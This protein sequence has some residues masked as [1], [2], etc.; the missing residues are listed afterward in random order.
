MYS[1]KSNQETENL[2]A[3]NEEEENKNHTEELSQLQLQL[4]DTRSQIA[5]DQRRIAELQDQIDTYAQRVQ[6]LENELYHRKD[7]EAKNMQEELITLEE[8]R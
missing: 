7:E 1:N 3:K 2:V 8:V 4:R 6:G 5:K